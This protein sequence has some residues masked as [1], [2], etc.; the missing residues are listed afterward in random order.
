MKVGEVRSLSPGAFPRYK[1]QC[2]EEELAKD[3]VGAA[4]VAGTEPNPFQKDFWKSRE[5]AFQE[6]SQMLLRGNDNEHSWYAGTGCTKMNQ[7]ARHI[8]GVHVLLIVTKYTQQRASLGAQKVKNL[9]SKQETRVWSLG[10]EDS[11]EK[12]IAGYPIQDSWLENPMDRE[13]W[14]ATAHGINWVT[15]TFTF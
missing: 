5:K 2:N 6:G 10:G 15:N 3:W 7:N 14:W 9:P 4:S 11:V 13:A 1:S 8:V 12:G